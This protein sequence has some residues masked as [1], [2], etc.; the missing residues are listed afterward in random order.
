[1]TSFF[2]VGRGLIA[3]SYY[4][5]D[6]WQCRIKSM[7]DILH[8]VEEAKESRDRVLNL[9][10][11]GL[12]VIPAEIS[13]LSSLHTLLLNNNQIIMPPEEVSHLRN[14]EH[15]SLE[16]NQLTLL[17]SVFSSLGSSL[18]FLNLSGNPLTYLPPVVCNLFKLTSLW[19]DHIGL[20]AF[21]SE[22]CCLTSLEKLSLVGNDISEIGDEI[23]NL[24]NLK[25]LSLANNRL[26]HLQIK[27][28]DD[29]HTK[30]GK[31]EILVLQGNQLTEVP[32]VLCALQKLA[33]VNLK[34]NK[35]TSLSSDALGRIA[36]SVSLVRVDVR[37]NPFN[38]QCGAACKDSK[39]Y[40]ALEDP[41]I[42]TV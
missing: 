34:R 18:K 41:R 9:S 27:E 1:M 26:N 3:A 38:M 36:Q 24:V 14:L 16:N 32:L 39:P 10:H 12:K 4:L 15:L 21:P 31:L 23:G 25:W 28:R 7:D 37:E 33:V 6:K 22:V 17:P 20:T 8:I 35:I 42:I 19:L 30:L 29:R 11:R 40:S 2:C 5:T 13:K